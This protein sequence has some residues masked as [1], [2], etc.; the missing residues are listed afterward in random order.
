MKFQ[1]PNKYKACTILHIIFFPSASGVEFEVV[2]AL[3]INPS[4]LDIYRH[5]FPKTKLHARNING[6]TADELNALKVDVIL[7]SPPCQPFCR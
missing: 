4:V 7:M 1:G 3:E 2:Q 5:N 6:V